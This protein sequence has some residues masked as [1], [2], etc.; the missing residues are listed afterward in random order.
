MVRQL[1]IRVVRGD[2]DATWSS[3]AAILEVLERRTFLSSN[4][5]V[6]VLLEP[7]NA[8]QVTLLGQHL[9]TN[10]DEYHYDPKYD[11]GVANPPPSPPW[12]S[13]D[14]DGNGYA[15]DAYGWDFSR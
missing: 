7:P 13:N 4:D 15:D 10:P 5:P 12:D 9:W 3:K 14:G 2:K 1:S 11:P 8:E 6:I